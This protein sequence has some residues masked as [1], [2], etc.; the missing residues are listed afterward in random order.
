MGENANTVTSSLEHKI[1]EPLP[2]SFRAH[3]A[4]SEVEPELRR[5]LD[6]LANITKYI[7]AKLTGSLSGKTEIHNTSG[8]TQ[9][10]LD[11]IAEDIIFQSLNSNPALSVSTY[12]SEESG[13]VRDIQVR[14]GRYSVMADPLDGSSV[15]DVNLSVGTIFGIHEGDFREGNS[16]RQT[17]KAAMYVL[18]GPRMTL[19]Y[20]TGNGVHEFERDLAGNFVRSLS[21]IRMKDTGSIYSPGGNR[22]NWSPEHAA[23]VKSLEDRNYILRYS[24]ALVPDFNQILLKGG[25]IFTYPAL[26][27]LPQGKLRMLFELQPL[28]FI[29][30]VAGGLAT[31]GANPILD[32][33]VHVLDGKSPIYIGSRSEV[34]LAASFLSSAKGPLY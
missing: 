23:F 19:V 12:A 4:I 10:K 27:T 13:R 7:Q 18:Y 30:E 28:A 5:L 34:H 1:G 6:D 25:G 20:T 16:G 9:I 8:D 33:P 3:L 11:Q 31:D 29:S 26:T 21:N 22:T 24:G 17:L 32:I 2:L 15:F 14:E